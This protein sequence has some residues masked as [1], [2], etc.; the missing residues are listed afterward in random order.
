MLKHVKTAENLSIDDNSFVVY[1]FLEC[2]YVYVAYMHICCICIF[3]KLKDKLNS[4]YCNLS[5]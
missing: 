1:A 5:N 4:L 2:V 3:G